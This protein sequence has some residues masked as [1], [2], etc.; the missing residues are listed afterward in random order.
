MRE[1]SL[2]SVV[3]DFRVQQGDTF[4]EQLNEYELFSRNLRQETGNFI[5]ALKLNLRCT[6]IPAPECDTLLGFKY[7]L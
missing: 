7:I 1:H 2:L 5:H 4:L 3:T 6:G